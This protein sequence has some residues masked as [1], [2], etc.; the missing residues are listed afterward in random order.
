MLFSDIQVFFYKRKYIRKYIFDINEAPVLTNYMIPISYIQ[1][2][3]IS[4]TTEIY[5]YT[6]FFKHK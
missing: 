4:T 1:Y 5:I 2:A 6:R 3:Q